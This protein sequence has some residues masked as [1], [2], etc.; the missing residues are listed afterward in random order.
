MPIRSHRPAWPTENGAAPDILV[1]AKS[2][3]MFVMDAGLARPSSP[4]FSHTRTSTQDRIELKRWLSG[5]FLDLRRNNRDR[6]RSSL[7]LEILHTQDRSAAPAP[8][9]YASMLS[10]SQSSSLVVNVANK[11]NLHCT[12]CYEPEDAKYGPSP[13]QMDWDTARDSV[14]FLFKK[15]WYEQR[16]ESDLLW[17]RSAAEFQTHASASWPML[18]KRLTVRRQELSTFHSRQMGHC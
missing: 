12:Y 18:K 7:A 9:A 3:S 5:Q 1:A 10:I 13:I 17:R 8:A 16:G 15:S 4:M 11:C 2:M 14:D 6:S